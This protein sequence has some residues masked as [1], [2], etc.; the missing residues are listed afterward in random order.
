LTESIFLKDNYEFVV[1][2]HQHF[3]VLLFFTIVGYTLIKYASKSSQELQ[4]KIGN[5]I[6]YFISATVL[7]W[8]IYKLSSNHFDI[9]NDL[10]F[11]LC[12]FLGLIMPLFT[13]TRKQLFYDILLFWV[14]AGTFQAIITPEARNGFP[15]IHFIY[16]WIVHSGLIITMLYA[17]FIYKMRPKLKSILISFIALQGYFIFV[18]IINKFTGANYFYLNAKPNAPSILDYLGEWP[19]YILMAELLLIPYFLIIYFP[20][21][22]SRVKK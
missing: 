3:L 2:G 9:T 18:S 13:R 7:I 6:A 8:T 4:I 11:Q 5:Y 12:Y 21:Y 10:P 20:F 16:F 22:L 15:H 17:T 1:F 19:N 14:F